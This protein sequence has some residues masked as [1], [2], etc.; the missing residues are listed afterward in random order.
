[1]H[2]ALSKLIKADYGEIIWRDR[3]RLGSIAASVSPVSH[4]TYLYEAVTAGKLSA[5]KWLVRLGGRVREPQD[6]A[7]PLPCPWHAALAASD[8]APML[9][10]LLASEA[11]TPVELGQCADDLLA[12]QWRTPT[13]R[14]ATAVYE[15]YCVACQRIGRDAEPRPLGSRPT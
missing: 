11:L 14:G 15:A 6:G 1:M 8:P 7:V 3:V 10:A 5:A 9:R 12:L 4:R 13:P 2:A